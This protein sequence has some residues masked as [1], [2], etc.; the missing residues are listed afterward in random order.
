MQLTDDIVHSLAN[1]HVDDDTAQDNTRKLFIGGLSW[2]T[3]EEGLRQYFENLGLHV[4]TVV[5]M[6]DK[7]GRSRGFGFLTL[8]SVEEI[9]KAVA[10]NLYLDGRKVEAKRAIPKSDMANHA[11][12]IFV[13]GI[14]ISLTNADFRKYFETFGKVLETQIMTDRES[15]RSRGFG[16][17]TFEEENVAAQVLKI[18]HT[19]Q[20]KPVEVKQ[21]EPKNTPTTQPVQILPLNPIYVPSSLSYPSVFGTPLSIEHA[22]FLVPTQTQGGVVYVPQIYEP[23][24]LDS[25]DNMNVNRH[26]YNFSD[27]LIRRSNTAPSV[28]DRPLTSDNAPSLRRHILYNMNNQK[29]QKRVLHTIYQDAELIPTSPGRILEPRTDR[30]FSE[31]RTERS[32]SAPFSNEIILTDSRLSKVI[33][34]P[35][36]KRRFGSQ[37]SISPNPISKPILSQNPNPLTDRT[38]RTDLN[39]RKPTPAETAPPSSPPLH[40]YFQ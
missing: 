18:S 5:I 2:M 8:E 30:A 13:G 24:T 22:A 28:I 36:V 31:P 3:T 25:S 19:I 40:K 9:D 16:F 26:A 12:K 1:L 11:K 29:E 38:R 33:T 27:P 6:R 4:D 39:W 32:F 23:V 21:A 34:P 20:G 14:P 37:N 17:V 15:G 10:I 35:V 7:T